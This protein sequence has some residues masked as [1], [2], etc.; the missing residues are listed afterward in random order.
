MEFRKGQ[1]QLDLNGT[2]SFAWSTKP[3]AIDKPTLAGLE[4]AGLEIYPCT[5][6]GNFEL[7]LQAAGIIEDP[8]Y[9][10]NVLKLH[11]L[12]K[13]HVW[14]VHRFEACVPNGCN[15]ELVF[16][17]L[18]CYADVYLNGELIG[19]CDN[20]LVEHTFN[21]DGL[22][23]SDNELL[24]HI[25]PAVLEAE[26]YPY[27]PGLSALGGNYESLYVRKAPH[28]YG[29]DIMP[30]AVSAGIW[31]PV[32]IRFLPI[33]RLEGVYLQTTSLSADARRADLD[34]YYR[35]RTLS[36]VGD[37]YEIAV[38]GR[39]GKASFSEKRR[40]GFNAGRFGFTVKDPQVW[41]PRGRG[42]PNLY[43]VT[44]SLMKNGRVV[45]RLEFDMGIR[46]VRLD[47][48]SVTS[49]SG[50]GEFC[51]RINGE[52]VFI[53]GSN[54][55]PLD[56]FHSRDIERISPAIELAEDIGCNMLRCWGGNV[57]ENDLFYELCD[58]KGIMVWQDFAMAC[59]IYPQD[60]EFRRRIAAEARKVVQRL[61]QHP[62][63]VLWSGDN[64]C[65]NVYL[66]SSGGK[67]DP[68][69]N[70]L[71]RKVLPQVLR[72]E[73]PTRP[74]LPSSPYI[75]QEAFAA[76]ERFLPENHLW[77][78]RNYYKSD[79]YLNALCHF[80]SE[81]G[82]HGCPS[83]DSI[84][85]FI[86]PEKLWPYKDNPQWLLH[87]TSP[88]PEAHLYDYRVELMAT[89]IR[90]LFGNV[91]DNLEQFALASQICQAEA[92]KFFI[93]FF[94]SAKW[95]R[96]GIIWWNLI[97]G[98]P[99]FSDAV[100]D[101]YFV[102]KLAYYYI[103]VSQQP[104]CLMLAEPEGSV[105]RLI[106]ANDTRE[107]AE[108]RY[109]LMDVETDDVVAEGTAVAMPDAV[110]TLTVVPFSKYDQRF[111]VIE[112][113]SARGSGKNHYLAGEPPFDLGQY[114]RWLEK[115]NLYPA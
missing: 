93:E 7:D 78:P 54:W 48:T 72:E 100:V 37:T 60:S 68:N 61:R 28:M 35:A 98:W 112:W 1:P 34:L 59:G 24:V 79:Y 86:S 11:E 110:T 91:P 17:G 82:Y 4:E 80:A 16:E 20:M 96:T 73:D 65:D 39:C 43:H 13:A 101:Y 106:A 107:I 57:Y 18:D 49:P 94:R 56:A 103:K 88:V 51:F 33:E 19:S 109:R 22:L 115:S 12:E 63:I 44:A 53:T 104:L 89:Q 41:W 81:I 90:E 97:D 52:K 108:L 8:F 50:D 64:E 111:Y 2:W 42:E 47:R 58:R 27:P 29:W 69:T 21:L 76:G 5:V 95:R 77:G 71:T 84:R 105:Q 9:A 45:D 46:T 74:Y 102:R 36:S 30:R 23:Q 75:D 31:R 62:C 25:K 32:R 85:R 87:S 3:A 14:Y 40:L 10:M 38:E 15:A 26:A 92:D 99:Q 55:V 67:R 113:E 6:P 66:W 70:V 83:P 114:L